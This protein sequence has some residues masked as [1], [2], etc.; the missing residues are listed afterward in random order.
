M[1]KMLEKTCRHCHRLL[2]M[3]AFY[4]NKFSPDGRYAVCKT[5]FDQFARKLKEKRH[6]KEQAAP[7]VP[8][9]LDRRGPGPGRITVK[10]I[11]NGCNKAEIIHVSANGKPVSPVRAWFCDVCIR[12]GTRRLVRKDAIIDDAAGREYKIT[13]IV[14]TEV[15]LGVGKTREGRWS[16]KPVRIHGRWTLPK[17]GW[18]T[19]LK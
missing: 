12:R 5:C 19:L 8:P 2:P 15:V 10:R 1:K 9:E 18:E 7:V 16:W 13:R 11:C 14:D 6:Q 4:E 3:D 17:Q